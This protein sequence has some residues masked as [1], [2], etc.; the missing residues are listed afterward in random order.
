MR[1]KTQSAFKLGILLVML[2][3]GLCL[4]GALIVF[5]EAPQ[6]YL[7]P[8]DVSQTYATDEI[9]C[10][11]AIPMVYDPDLCDLT[12]SYSGTLSIDPTP[13]DGLRYSWNFGDGGTSSTASGT[14][15]YA[16]P[17]Q[18]TV[19][20][21]VTDPGSA[22]PCNTHTASLVVMINAKP[23]VDFAADQRQSCAPFAVT[24]TD[25][26]VAETSGLEINRIVGW[27]WDFGDGSTSPLSTTTHTYMTPG[28]YNVS[29]I[30]T[31]LVGCM[32][33]LQKEAY[34]TVNRPPVPSFTASP[35]SGCDPLIVQ[36]NDTSI[37]GDYPIVEWLWDF[38]DQWLGGIGGPTIGTGPMVIHHYLIPGTYWATLTVIDSQGCSVTSPPVEIN[39]HCDPVA[40]ATDFAVCL[41]TTLSPQLFM[42]QGAT[43]WSCGTMP[44][45]DFS[46]VNTNVPGVYEYVVTCATEFCVSSDVGKITVYA[47]PEANFSATPRSCCANPLLTVQ[48]TDESTPGY[49]GNLIRHWLWDF[50]DGRTS[51]LQNPS[52]D[53]APGVYNVTL[54]VIDAF[55]CSS[56][57]QEALYITSHDKPRADFDPS[58]MSCCPPV[59][60]FTDRSSQGASPSEPIVAWE[61][62][63]DGNG[64]FETPGEGPQTASYPSGSYAVSLRVTDGH[65]C[66]D[67]TTIRGRTACTEPPSPILRPCAAAIACRLRCGLSTPPGRAAT[68]SRAGCGTLAMAPQARSPIRCISTRP[69][70]PSK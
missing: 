22:P 68:L 70:V 48:F 3:I 56:S 46:R 63:L 37:V 13:A 39:V 9:S 59:M 24:F 52:H 34:I 43:C 47:P 41:G 62:D 60:M 33:V 26:S 1:S 31:D 12:I 55:G 69:L 28:T 35:S 4:V 6:K 38:G 65:G 58:L 30:V 18:Y 20:L 32:S 16:A 10:T 7:P 8:Q 2:A 15:T 50:G 5:A 36:F 21:T 57:I 66:S 44:M 42:E 29:L 19:T 49:S 64:T 40:V 25:L 14:H 67:V 53:Y 17:G 51:T 27:R 11:T 54:T 45:Y 61:W 23:H